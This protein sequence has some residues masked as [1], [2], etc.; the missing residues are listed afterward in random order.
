MLNTIFDYIY[1]QRNLRFP[2][3]HDDWLFQ[4]GYQIA[5]G[6][7]EGIRRHTNLQFADNQYCF[8]LMLL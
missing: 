4:D 1:E 6:T 5:V 3:R 8:S 7:D 2:A